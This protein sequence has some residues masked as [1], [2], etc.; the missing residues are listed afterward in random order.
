MKFT[1]NFRFS[2]ANWFVS[3]NQSA[4]YEMR[5]TKDAFSSGVELVSPFSH[6]YD[7]SEGTTTFTIDLSRLGPR[8]KIMGGWKRIPHVTNTTYSKTVA[9][10]R[11][12]KYFLT[13]LDRR[14]VP[15]D[16]HVNL[17]QDYQRIK[18]HIT[19]ARTEFKNHDESFPTFIS[20]NP[21][22]FDV[23]TYGLS[24]DPI[25]VFVPSDFKDGDVD[26]YA[27]IHFTEREC[28]FTDVSA[29][30][31]SLT[32]PSDFVLPEG[33]REVNT[34]RVSPNSGI[35]NFEGQGT[36]GY[37]SDS[38]FLNTAGDNTPLT[39]SY[40]G[41]IKSDDIRPLVRLNELVTCMDHVKVV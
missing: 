8:D 13:H 2:L 14:L 10:K 12:L 19:D 6:T 20:S 15:L 11:S 21:E 17:E 37:G 38:F 9:G 33:Y 16:I 23:K 5:R 7:E 35:M 34:R 29:T 32:L 30:F 3:G 27:N 36:I 26:W 4:D 41:V 40:Q 18:A 25:R 31:D 28:F 1:R 22:K 39:L 24:G